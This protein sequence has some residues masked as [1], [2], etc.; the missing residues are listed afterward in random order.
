MHWPGAAELLAHPTGL[1][2]RWVVAD[3]RVWQ[4]AVIGS[5]LALPCPFIS[6][7]L[8]GSALPLEA[9]STSGMPGMPDCMV[10]AHLPHL[11]YAWCL[12]ISH[13]S[14]SHR[15]TSAAGI[16]HAVYILCTRN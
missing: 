10:P 2:P 9:C 3:V 14:H 13:I 5:K 4:E 12:P 6:L 16:I 15:P 11:I 1:D 8:V 7:W